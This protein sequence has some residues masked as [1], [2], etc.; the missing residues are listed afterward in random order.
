MPLC[1]CARGWISLS[2]VWL[3]SG[4]C[5]IP[6]PHFPLAYAFHMIILQLLHWASQTPGLSCTLPPRDCCTESGSFCTSLNTPIIETMGFA[7][8]R[9]NS[10]GG[11]RARREGLKPASR[12][13]LRAHRD[14]WSRDDLSTEEAGV[15]GSWE[16]NGMAQGLRKSNRITGNVDEVCN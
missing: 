10:W 12:R 7:E 3:R 2:P 14:G 16:R 8:E 11:L 5:V 9:V 13:D 4:V 6:V 1:S 15:G